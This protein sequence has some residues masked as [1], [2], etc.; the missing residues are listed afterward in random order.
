MKK[1]LIFVLAFMIVLSCMTVAFADTTLGAPGEGVSEVIITTEAPIFSATV[2]ATLA[3]SV[4]GN[5]TVVTATNAKITNNSYGAIQVTGLKVAGKNGW[6]TVD[7]A[8]SNMAN[9]RVG[10]KQ[11]AISLNGCTTTGKDSIDFI[12][13][14]FPAISGKGGDNNTLS[15]S[16]DAKVPI[17]NEVI[18]AA[19]GILDVTFILSWYT[20]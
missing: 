15:I 12:Q 11:I 3:I 19:Q 2:P 1:N 5:G 6:E 9:V 13:S 8:T 17:Q 7:Y 20:E 10:S 16:Y 18:Y 14:N 4:A